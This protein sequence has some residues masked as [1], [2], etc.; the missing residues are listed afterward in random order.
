MVKD[1]IHIPGEL[2][3]FEGNVS[4]YDDKITYRFEW[5]TPEYEKSI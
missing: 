1:K 3:E 2:S 5:H 4:D